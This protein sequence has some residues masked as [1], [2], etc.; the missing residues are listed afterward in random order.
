MVMEEEVAAPA[1][2]NIL[3]SLGLFQ[4]LAGFP[5]PPP[6]AEPAEEGPPP[7]MALPRGVMFFGA[8]RPQVT[9]IDLP[10]ATMARSPGYTGGGP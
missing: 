10:A 2:F 1:P 4:A 8:G 9:T 3:D 5:T 6:A 7:P